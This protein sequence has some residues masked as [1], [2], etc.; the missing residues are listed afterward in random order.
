MRRP[1]DIFL[2]GSVVAI[3]IISGLKVSPGWAVGAAFA[4]G[5]IINDRVKKYDA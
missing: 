3:L 1:G 4:I 5:W 2:S